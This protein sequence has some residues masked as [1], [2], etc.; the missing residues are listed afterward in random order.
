MT[1]VFSK[2]LMNRIKNFEDQ[3]ELLQRAM[4]ISSDEFQPKK[5]RDEAESLKEVNKNSNLY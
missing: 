5:L 4:K 2:P 3:I 1:S